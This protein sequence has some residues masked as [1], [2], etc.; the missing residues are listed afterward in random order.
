MAQIKKG[1]DMG[2][3]NLVLET[4]NSLDFECVQTI[5][6]IGANG[7][8]GGSVARALLEDVSAR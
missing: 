4:S 5:A 1:I 2:P 3:A 7:A 6:V 8:Q